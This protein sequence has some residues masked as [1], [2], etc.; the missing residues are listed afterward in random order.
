MEVAS[1][2]IK[3]YLFLM[4][5]SVRP[6]SSFEM[7]THWLPSSACACTR[8]LQSTMARHP[9]AALGTKTSDSSLRVWQV[10]VLVTSDICS[11]DFAGCQECGD[12]AR[13]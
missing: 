10:L 8:I 13:M 4:A 6:G 7:C 2:L 3:S 5:L 9:R 11:G 1:R 12:G